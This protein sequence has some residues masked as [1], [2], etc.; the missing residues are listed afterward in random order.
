M[1]PPYQVF[2][3]ARGERV[4][5]IGVVTN[6]TPTIVS[7]TGITDVEFLD[8]ADAVNRWVPELRKA[9][10]EAIGV[11]I[12]EGVRRRDRAPWTPTAATSSP[13]RSWTSTTGST[14]R[15]TSS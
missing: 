3:T 11:L 13:C 5:L 9:G 10:V 4:A 6:T 14:P 1:L 7:P 15:S 2:F 8:E 12:H